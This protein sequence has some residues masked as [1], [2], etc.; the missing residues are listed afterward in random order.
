M[1]SIQ[2]AH[3]GSY[4]G[5]ELTVDIARPAAEIKTADI[6]LTPNPNPIEHMASVERIWGGQIVFSNVPLKRL[7]LTSAPNL[8]FGSVIERELQLFAPGATDFFLRMKTGEFLSPPKTHDPGFFFAWMT[9][10][11]NLA[12]DQMEDGQRSL[13]FGLTVFN[14]TLSDFPSDNWNAAAPAEVQAVLGKATSLPHPQNRELAKRTYLLPEAPGS[15]L[16][17]FSTTDGAQGLLQITGFTENPR[18]V[19]FRYKLVQSEKK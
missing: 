3:G 19:K 15:P 12:L 11:V 10:N 4:S 14:M 7:D 5:E 16:L 18:G 1:W 8:S 17:A 13:R 6:I 9:N 2:T